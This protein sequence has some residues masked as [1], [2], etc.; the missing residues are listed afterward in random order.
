[1]TDRQIE[2]HING[3]KDKYTVKQS[4]LKVVLL[5]VRNKWEQKNV[6]TSLFTHNGNANAWVCLEVACNPEEVYSVLSIGVNG[7]HVVT[8]R[9]EA[10]GSLLSDLLTIAVDSWR[11]EGWRMKKGR[12]V[13]EGMVGRWLLLKGR[14]GGRKTIRERFK[15][16]VIV[17][18]KRDWKRMNE[19]WVSW[20]RRKVK[21]MKGLTI[22]WMLEV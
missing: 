22:Y 20:L 7:V 8:E 17:E 3:Q 1:M 18:G 13:R 10:L 19:R 6:T 16:R 9:V 11:K 21:I 14:G 5:T 12:W 4:E 2:R 15:G